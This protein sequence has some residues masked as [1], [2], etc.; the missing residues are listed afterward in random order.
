MKR[1]D[2]I[3]L[4]VVIAFLAPFFLYPSVFEWYRSFNSDHAYLASFLKFA[5]LATFGE[6][7]GLRIRTGRYIRPG[8]GLFPRAIVWGFL[9]IVLK[10]AFVIFAEGSPSVLQSMGILFPD[11]NPADILRQSHFSWVKLVSAFSAG[12]FL[13]IFFA[14]VF[15]VF[16]RISD[17]HITTTGGTLSGF[18]SPIYFRKSFAD[19]D[20]DSMWN[21]VLKKTIPFFWIPAQTLNFMLPEEWRILVA[22]IYSIILGILLS[23]AGLMA[24]RRL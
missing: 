11:P 13:N 24:E 2:V 12:F 5:L 21:F 1:T 7:I 16:H 3:V 20:W 10:T 17:M 22:A 8:F 4:L 19:L 18:F 23:V 9:G 6:S 14:P 15:M